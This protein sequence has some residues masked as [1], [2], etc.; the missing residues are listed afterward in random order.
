MDLSSRLAA[1]KSP[2]LPPLVL[3][4]PA[5]RALQIVAPFIHWYLKHETNN[6]TLIAI[7]EQ[8]YVRIPKSNVADLRSHYLCDYPSACICCGSIRSTNGSCLLIG[9]I[10]CFSGQEKRNHAP[11][12]LLA[13]CFDLLAWRYGIHYTHIESS[14]ANYLS[15]K[16]NY[17]FSREIDY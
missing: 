6:S 4:I 10:V 13:H 16:N 8:W 7:M 12:Y 1:L 2:P 9:C 3:P 5:S 15:R 14:I 17:E 11:Q